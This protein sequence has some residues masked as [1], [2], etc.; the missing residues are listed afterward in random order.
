MLN[1][2]RIAVWK[3]GK[4][5]LNLYIRCTSVLNDQNFSHTGY[6]HQALASIQISGT[7]QED[8]RAVDPPYS[9]PRQQLRIRK[10]PAK[11][12]FGER[13]VRASTPNF[14]MKSTDPW[15]FYPGGPSNEVR[16]FPE[17]PNKLVYLLK[18]TNYRAEDSFAYHPKNAKKT[19]MVVDADAESNFVLYEALPMEARLKKHKGENYNLRAAKGEMITTVRELQLIIRRRDYFPIA[20]F[21]VRKTLP[22]NI[23]PGTEVQDSPIEIPNHEEQFFELPNGQRLPVA[24]N[25]RDFQWNKFGNCWWF[26]FES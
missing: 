15:T 13:W 6:L 12:K 7:M 1:F 11:N 3:L 10:L 24:R 9:A 5:H 2:S 8:K 22:Y 19:L 21:V 18:L 23:M 16:E 26:R 14:P 17:K 4:V 20:R 25:G